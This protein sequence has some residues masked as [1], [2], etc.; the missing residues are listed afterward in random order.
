MAFVDYWNELRGVV[1]KLSAPLAQ[2]LVN[3]A[4]LDIRDARLWSWQ[5]A[6]GGF[7]SPDLI[8]TGTVT[9][10]LGDTDVIVNAAAK[11]VLDAVVLDP[12]NPL[13]KRQFRVASQGPIYNISSYNSGT[14]TIT[15]DRVYTE[16]SA[17]GA[18]YQVYR[19]YYAPPSTDF[20]CWWSIIDPNNGYPL[21]F[22]RYRTKADLD[23]VDPNRGSQGQAYYV[24]NY[25]Y[26]Q[27]NHYPLFELWPQ[28]TETQSFQY[29]YRRKG[30]DLSATNDLPPTISVELLMMRSRY[31]AYE[32]AFSNKGLY[33]ELR[34]IDW[35]Y[36]MKQCE[37]SRSRNPNSYATALMRA[38]RQDEQ[39]M[40]QNIII[41]KRRRG[42]PI[43]AAFM[44][45]HDIDRM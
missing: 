33:A 12:L 30:L 3:R 39:I 27:V 28:P 45:S 38:K 6:D 44:Q 14:S 24:A 8:S 31:R 36:L 22:R 7:S 42:F 20:I 16:A 11:A 2:K 23:R 17:S 18:S 4:W 29:V 10:T 19:C 26:D 35:G 13:T 43:D 32:W 37:D 15:L 5:V 21:D 40:V 1:P 25:K 41:L 9:V 34:G